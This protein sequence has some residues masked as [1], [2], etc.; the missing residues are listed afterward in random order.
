VQF[1]AKAT[2]ET[3]NRIYKQADQMKVTLGER[4][5]RAADAL[6]RAVE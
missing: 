1:N 4:M 2:A 6:E 3:I 5:E